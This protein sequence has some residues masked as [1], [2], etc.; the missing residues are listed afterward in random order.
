[1]IDYYHL[2]FRKHHYL[3]GDETLIENYDLASTDKTQ[4]WVCHHRRELEPTRKTARQL[5]DED[6]YW[7][8]PPEELI[9]LTNEEHARLHCHGKNNVMYGRSSWE[10]LDESTRNQRISIFKDKMRGR[11]R[12]KH[13]YHDANGVGYF[14]DDG[15]PRIVELNLIRGL[16]PKGTHKSTGGYVLWN[17]GTIQLKRRECPGPGWIRGGIKK[18]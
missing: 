14:C 7:N 1:M 8:R 10:G 13:H 16:P 18:E 9:F 2:K 5:M 11:N 4:V 17:N 3:E 15:D 6:L 12:G